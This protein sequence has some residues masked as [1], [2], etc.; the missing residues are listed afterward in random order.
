MFQEY[1][2][3]LTLPA[4]SPPGTWVLSEIVIRDKAGNTLTSDFIETGIIR[5][6]EVLGDEGS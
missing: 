2:I 6:I 1:R 3:D 4:G 5:P